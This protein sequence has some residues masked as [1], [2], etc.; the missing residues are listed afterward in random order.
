MSKLQSAA[1][2]Y[3]YTLIDPRSQSIFYVGKGT[4]SRI[5]QHEKDAE[6]FAGVCS[7]KL[8][9][10]RDIHACNACVGKA[11]HAYFWDEQAAY[12]YETDLIEE[13]GLQNLTNVLPGGQKAWDQRRRERAVRRDQSVPM[14]VWLAKKDGGTNTLFQRFAEWFRA[15]LHKGD[16]KV[17]CTAADPK[18]KWNASIT[19]AVYN[20]MLP[21]LWGQIHK[22]DKARAVFIERIRPYGVELVYGSA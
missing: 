5:H 21:H 20:T 1:R 16:R 22:D 15:D 13:I 8:N 12:D 11:F 10:I 9:K 2:W 19:E 3:V 6:K 18:F 4:G 7:K 14:H 17:V